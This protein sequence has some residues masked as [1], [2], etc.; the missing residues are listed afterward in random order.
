M[1][2]IVT[3][4]PRS[5]LR[6]ITELAMAL[7]CPIISL[8]YGQPLDPPSYDLCDF[9]SKLQSEQQFQYTLNAGR[10]ETRQ[11][12]IN[13]FDINLSIDNIVI[14]AGATS[15]FAL[16]MG[17]LINPGDTVLVPDPGYPNFTFN[18]LHYGA[19]VVYYHL[20]KE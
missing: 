17:C 7:D 19:K 16:I 14:T 13:K 8:G 3:Q 20:K 2:K 1:N 10:I 9:L 5:G 11:A 4:Y 18:A 6:D 12:I 15:A